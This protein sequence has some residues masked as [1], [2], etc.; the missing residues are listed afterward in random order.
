MKRSLARHSP[1]FVIALRVALSFV[2]VELYSRSG[3]LAALGVVL[4]I[5][6]IA[7]DALDGYLARRF[8]VESDLGAVMDIAGDRIVEHVFWIYFAVAG[9][10]PL[11][12]PLLIMTR[13][14]L[15]DSLRSVALAGGRTPFGRT[16]MMRS[17]LTRFL[18]SSRFMRN[19]YG[20]VK[21]FAFVLLGTVIVI[22]KG[23]WAELGLPTVPGLESWVASLALW[24]SLGAVTLNLVRGVPVLLDS[25]SL[26]RV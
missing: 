25:R 20:A 15:V 21:V 13:S 22:G 1:D 10:V 7:M 14:F 8:G 5:V 19:A 23:G 16:T 9:L 11:W 12:I 3:S 4:T 18:T 24:T 17:P 26:F 6:V 2:V